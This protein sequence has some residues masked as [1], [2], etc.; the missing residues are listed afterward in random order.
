MWDFKV[1]IVAPIFGGDVNLSLDKTAPVGSL[2]QAFWGVIRREMALY[3]QH[4]GDWAMPFLFFIMVVALF[5]LTL[6][7]GAD[8]LAKVAPTVIWIAVVL[9]LI[10]SLETIFRADF[11]TGVLDQ[12]GISPYPLSVLMLGKSVAHWIMI[13]VP[14]LLLA[15]LLGGLFLLSQS[16]LWVL[17]LTLFFGIP[18]LSLIGALGAA[19]TIG[20]P[21][22]G[23]LLAILVLPWMIPVLLFGAS[24]L[25]AVTEGR[26]FNSELLLLTAIFIAT[27]VIAP[28]GIS[29]AVRISLES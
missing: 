24:A 29:A 1:F 5:S 17:F 7:A 4:R 25:V 2:S 12:L 23:V 14:L 6:G 13:G 15:P 28:M 26:S 3:D 18:T 19:L 16:E 21:Q 9:A 8:W 10:L 11:Q 20:L 22:G 27:L